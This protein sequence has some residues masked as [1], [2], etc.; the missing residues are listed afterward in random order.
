MAGK[1]TKNK[2]LSSPRV[3][4]LLV[5]YGIHGNILCFLLILFIGTCGFADITLLSIDR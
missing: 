3:Q 2:I 4:L 5:S 1:S